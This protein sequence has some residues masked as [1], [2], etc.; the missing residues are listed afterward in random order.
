MEDLNIVYIT[1]RETALGFNEGTIQDVIDYCSKLE[2]IPLDIEASSLDPYLAVPLLISIGDKHKQFVIDVTTVEDFTRLE[3]LTDKTFIGHNI[4][5]DAKVLAT[6]GIKFKHIYDSLIVEQTIRK[7]LKGGNRLDE[8]K[9]RYLKK[10]YEVNKAIRN[11]FIGATKNFEFNRN[12]IIYSAEDV[13]DLE[14]IVEHQAK[15]IEKHGLSDWLYKV[16]FPLCIGLV[17]TENEGLTLDTEKWEALTLENKKKKFVLEKEMDEDLAELANT[18]YPGL[19]KRFKFKPRQKEVIEQPDMFGGSTFKENKNVNNVNFSSEKQ[20]KQIFHACGEPIPRNKDT[21]KETTG[22]DALKSHLIKVEGLLLEP[23]L[24]K[25][26]DFQ[27]INKNISSFGDNFIKMINPVTNRLHTLYR[28]AGADTGRFQSGDTKNNFFN[29]QQ[30]P[31]DKRYRECF[32]RQEGYNILTIDLSGAELVILASLAEDDRL[33]GILEDPHS[34]LATVCYAAVLKHITEIYNGLSMRDELAKI[35]GSEERA[36]EYIQSGKFIITKKNAKDLR[37]SF[38]AVIYGLAYGATA[39][40]V[41]EVLAIP[42]DYAEIIVN[43]LRREIPKTFAYLDRNSMFGVQNGFI[44]L[45]DRAKTRRWFKDVVDAKRYHFE[46]DFKIINKIKRECKNSPIQGTQACMVK[47][48]AVKIYKY[49]EDNS[50]D[51]NILMYIHDELV[52]RYPKDNESF[53]E[54][55]RKILCDTCNL[56]LKNGMKMDAEYDIKETWTK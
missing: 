55:I 13:V 32:A 3:E 41:A 17:K 46:L 4:K 25:L 27:T 51:A 21:D 53:P 56:Y 7:G 18:Y 28:Q 36:E 15:W 34:P 52:L 44:T 48:S 24:R 14:D 9:L 10:E 1:N 16:E 47:E 11:E 42:M 6:H 20:V 8:V 2:N 31:K 19:G 33:A 12:H 26:I 50:I 29:S 49:I 30:I 35:L 23:F 22:A 54:D 38:K 45:C 5:Y 39:M 40:R 43:T 37:D